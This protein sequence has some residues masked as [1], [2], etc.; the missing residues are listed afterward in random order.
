MRLALVLFVAVSAASCL[1]PTT[2][3]SSSNCAG[4]CDSNGDCQLGTFATQCGFGGAACQACTSGVCTSNGTCAVV[5]SGGGGGSSG[6]GGGSSG[7][8]A[9]TGGGG[10]GLTGGGAATGGGATNGGGAATGGAGGGGVSDAGVSAFD[11]SFLDA[12][13]RVATSIG[14][15]VN[16]TTQR[17]GVA[18]Y[19]PAG[20][21][22]SGFPDYFL[23]YVEWQQGAIVVSP[24]TI[25]TSQRLSTLSVAFDPANG[26]P[27][28]AHLGGGAGALMGMS[29]YWLQSDAVFS[30]RT[31]PNAWTDVIVATDGNQVTCGNPVS[32][33][34]FLV[35]LFPNIGFDGTGKL[36]FAYRDSH[37]G[38]FPMQDFAA[39][40][41][42]VWGGNP[43]SGE[44]AAAGGNN[45]NGVGGHLQMT[46]EASNRVALAFDQVYAADQSGQNVLFH[47]RAP[48]GM[49]TMPT[50]ILSVT[51]T[52]TGP[53]LASDP[54]E[55][56]GIA[57][58][59]RAANELKYIHS[60]NGTV[61]SQPDPVFGAGSGGWYPHLA[62]DPVNHEP[63]ITFYVCSTSTSTNELNCPVGQ[64][65]L[66]VTQRIGGT[67]GDTLV[68]LEGGFSPKLGFFDS[69]KRVVVYRVP[70]AVLPDGGVV[71]NEGALK[72][73][74]ER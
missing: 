23:K 24:E 12:T 35:G 55:G 58:L 69:G 71:L 11:V 33:R 34:G 17:V 1:T 26:Q 62:M 39:S 14:I 70:P 54:V 46:I 18:Y 37:D 40:D 67:W 16:R 48:N 45:R 2:P 51:N 66:R 28:V 61:W 5:L 3:C 59:E 42:E 64:D 68:D 32:D 31:G 43:L 74:V 7:G 8:G 22:T 13:A 19:S 52:Q 15:A 65:E 41:V 53:S 29:P 49:W 72:I 36:Y 20:T 9:A 44:C 30:R 27:L 38:Q 60:S 21:M 73:A 57:V 4:C 50:T 10:G 25:R 6:G 47:V 56:F 63:A